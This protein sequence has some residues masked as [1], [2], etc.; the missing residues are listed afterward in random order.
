MK[1]FTMDIRA[2]PYYEES[3]LCAERRSRLARFKNEK[4]RLLSLAAELVL[5]EAVRS[6]YP[7]AKLPLRYTRNEH[8]KPFLTDYPELNFNLSHSG[9][10]AVCVISER[11]IGVDIQ[12]TDRE[13]EGI[14]ERFF[15]SDE[16]EYIG[17]SP[18][19]FFEVWSMKESY[20]KARGTGMDVPLDSFSVFK[21]TDCRFTKCDAPEGGY[22]LWVC[23]MD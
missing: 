13:H 23:E 7:D 1:I 2:L 20:L 8:G 21:L 12:T 15:T 17:E 10:Y 6:V 18:D 14:A 11:S 4:A 3:W 9:N 19:N 16:C 22:V 5:I